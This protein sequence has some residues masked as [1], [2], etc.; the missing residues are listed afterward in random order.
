MITGDMILD[1]VESTVKK[2]SPPHK[3]GILK[4]IKCTIVL[5]GYGG[6]DI[7]SGFTIT[8]LKVEY[9]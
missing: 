2:F 8:E 4:P 5:S 9:A 1:I 6:E 3:D 7:D